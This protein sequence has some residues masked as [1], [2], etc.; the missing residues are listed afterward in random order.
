MGFGI[1]G[2]CIIRSISEAVEGWRARE[3]TGLAMAT[4]AQLVV[5]D[6]SFCGI[7]GEGE[8]GRVMMARRNQ[9]G[10]VRSLRALSRWLWGVEA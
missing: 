2:L 6:F 9:T 8:F 10:E 7:L 3:H 4:E 5:T 1:R